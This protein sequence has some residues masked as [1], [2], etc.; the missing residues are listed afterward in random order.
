M[1]K[2]ISIEE[3][4]FE[5]TYDLEVDHKDHQFYLANGALTSNSHAAAYATISAVTAWAKHHHRPEAIAAS[6]RARVD[7]SG[8]RD[9][10]SRYT[11]EAKANGIDLVLFDPSN[12]IVDTTAIDGAVHLGFRF[13]AGV[14][15][16]DVPRLERGRG[17]TDILGWVD[18]VSPGSSTIVALARSGCFDSMLP[19]EIPTCIQAEMTKLGL[20]LTSKMIFETLLWRLCIEANATSIAKVA[21]E[22]RGQ[23]SLFSSNSIAWEP[24]RV[25][26]HRL[27]ASDKYDVWSHCASREYASL[28]YAHRVHGAAL[29]RKRLR[30]TAPLGGEF[31]DYEEY[32]V[33]GI[34]RSYRK[35]VTKNGDDM[36]FIRIEDE[37]G[38]QD[39]VIFSDDLEGFTHYEGDVARMRVFVD[40]AD[41]DSDQRFQYRR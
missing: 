4:G 16:E 13:I 27:E 6:L 35:I 36:A 28:G 25:W 26:P 24:P 29:E 14:S 5:D 39:V 7:D 41:A 9:N 20:P 32:A 21:R 34:V 31:R 17:K 22:S 30:G 18:E 11:W 33:C 38:G 12:P 3:V 19:D 23:M 37:T 10:V 15:V 40:R 8:D 1:A 2:V